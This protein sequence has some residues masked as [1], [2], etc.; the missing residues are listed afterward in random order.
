MS[1][2]RDRS[3]AIR[4]SWR[5]PRALPGTKATGGGAYISPQTTELALL[6]SEPGGGGNGWIAHAGEAS[7]Y[8]GNWR[9]AATAICTKVGPWSRSGRHHDLDAPLWHHDAPEPAVR[10]DG[11]PSKRHPF[12]AV[13]LLARPP[14]RLARCVPR[15]RGATSRDRDQRVHLLLVDRPGPPG[16]S[17][18]GL[19]GVTITDRTTLERVALEAIPAL[20]GRAD[21]PDRRRTTSTRRFGPGCGVGSVSAVLPRPVTLPTTVSGATPPDAPPAP[22]RRTARGAPPESPGCAPPRRSV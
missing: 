5:S 8:A 17:D 15:I 20:R 16:L 14:L 13:R 11:R 18:R 10:V 6:R 21:P 19:G 12:P 2:W 9:V 7:P 22:P 4:T 3:T 1:T